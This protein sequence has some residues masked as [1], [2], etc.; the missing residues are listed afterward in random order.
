LSN[1]LEHDKWV[2]VVAAFNMRHVEYTI[3]P[4][5][6]EK[7]AKWYASMHNYG[8]NGFKVVKLVSPIGL[9]GTD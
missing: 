4:F 3:G 8:P 5:I 9:M 2:I 6:S 1:E 7:D